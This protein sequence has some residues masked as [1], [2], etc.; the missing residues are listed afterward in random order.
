MLLFY[1]L[2]LTCPVRTLGFPDGSVV[3]NP[4]AVQETQETQAQSLGHGRSPGGGNSNQSSVLAQETP[5]TEEP[6]G[7]QSKGWQ[8][9]GHN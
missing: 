5:W 3:Q 4:P 6:G 1:F 7:L 2:Q 8:R 9:V